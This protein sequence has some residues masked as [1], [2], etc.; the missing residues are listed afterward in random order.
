M[1]REASSSAAIARARPEDLGMS[2][3]RLRSLGERLNEDV[4]RQ[5]L[6]GAVALVARHGRVVHFEAYGTRDPNA[7]EPMQLDTIFRVHS[8]TKPIVSV[9]AMM[10]VEAGR[11]DLADPLSLYLP[12]FRHTLVAQ[13]SGERLD[14]IPTVRPILI[15][16]LFRHTSGL[17][18][19]WLAEGPTRRL[20]AEAQTER[21]DRTN[22]ERCDVLAGLPLLA[23]PGTRWIYGR[24]TDVLGRVIEVVADE[25]LGEHL[26]NRVF[27]PLGMLETGFHVP[28]EQWHR[29]AEPFAIDP[30]SGA[31]VTLF[32]VRR[33]VAFENGGG[34]LVSTT[35]DYSRFLRMV[36][37]GGACGGVRLVSPATLDF[38]LCDHLGPE[39]EIGPEFLPPGYGFGL[40]FAV[41]RTT[42]IA[43]FPGTAGDVFWEGL[44]G[45][46][47]WIDRAR[48]LH[49]ILMIQAPGR[50]AHY[51]SLFR[52][53]VYAAL[54]E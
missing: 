27:A 6:P 2:S 13:V 44:G 8:M 18:Y 10:L 39:V 35:T 20:Y 53:L 22:A 25:S 30:D 46:N 5:R 14:R 17:A 38:M 50:R 31:A 49:A 1:L 36:E 52:Q 12:A 45:T 32:D 34:G 23:Q 7:G 28:S 15:H 19:E 54:T 29:L 51:R 11:L 24:S 4:Q 41:R 16:D 3:D 40:G 42:G 33:A 26:R 48:G 9:A 43:P 47:F 37:N 21:R